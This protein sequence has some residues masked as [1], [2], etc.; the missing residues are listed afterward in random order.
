M[1]RILLVL[2]MAALLGACVPGGVRPPS[3]SN[4]DPKGET[5]G[6]DPC[7][8]DQYWSESSKA[9]REWPKSL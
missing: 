4:V 6:Q 5:Q 3:Y 8:Q 9:C 1:K 2:S 7:P